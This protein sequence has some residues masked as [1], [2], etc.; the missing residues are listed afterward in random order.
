MSFSK[1][2][3]ST[4]M[5]FGSGI[6]MFQ[7]PV[8]VKLKAD[9]CMQ[10]LS[11]DEVNVFTMRNMLQHQWTEVDEPPTDGSIAHAGADEQIDKYLDNEYYISNIDQ[12]KQRI[13][14]WEPKPTI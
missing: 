4:Q 12:S 2:F 6:Q 10:H 8:K 9:L 14:I 5:S 7:I 3:F 13:C 11:T 1:P